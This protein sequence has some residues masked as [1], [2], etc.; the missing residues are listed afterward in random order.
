ML[1]L[2]GASCRLLQQQQ[3]NSPEIQQKHNYQRKKQPF[4]E[5][6]I[7]SIQSQE[8]VE[9]KEEDNNIICPRLVVQTIMNSGGN[10]NNNLNN[11]MS[12]TSV[13]SSPSCASHAQGLRRT[14][15]I[16]SL[17]QQCSAQWAVIEKVVGEEK[18]R[19]NNDDYEE[20]IPAHTGGGG[21]NSSSSSMFSPPFSSFCSPF[22]LQMSN[23][24]AICPAP[25]NQVELDFSLEPSSSQN[26][27]VRLLIRS[28]SGDSAQLFL[29]NGTPTGSFCAKNSKCCGHGQWS[30]RIND[31]EEQCWTLDGVGSLHFRVLMMK[32]RGHYGDNS[33]LQWRLEL[34]DQEFLRVPAIATCP[35]MAMIMVKQKKLNK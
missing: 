28:P 7:T 35:L 18:G 4:K 33:P 12:S 23:A 34:V 26:C 1:L 24:V 8:E 22:L 32:G 20:N 19:N 16:S 14:A 21:N 13:S 6:P 3:Q 9:E 5:Q 30:V 10:F 29:S 15:A 17:K 31:G 2:S 27:N 11:N 25:A